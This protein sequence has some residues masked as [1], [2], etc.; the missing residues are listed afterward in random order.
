MVK[1]GNFIKKYK[2]KEKSLMLGLK[3]LLI[4]GDYLEWKA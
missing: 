3:S 2:N 4:G 1:K